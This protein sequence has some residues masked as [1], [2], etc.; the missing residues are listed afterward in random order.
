MRSFSIGKLLISIVALM[1]AF[2]SYIFDWNETHIFNSKWPPHAKFHNAQ[3]MALGTMLGLLGLYFLWFRKGNKQH[4]LQLA[5]LFSALYW[6][7]QVA[8]SVFPG[9]A[10]ADPDFSYPGQ[11]PAQLIVC[12]VLF[13]L[14]G[15]GYVAELRHIDKQVI[16]NNR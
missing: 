7:G 11:P 1:T 15:I 9:T 16:Q 13:V 6:L 8:A 12:I 3:T 14:L 2:G 10:L 5:V 4:T